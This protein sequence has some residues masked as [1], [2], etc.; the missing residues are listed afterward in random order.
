MKGQRWLKWAGILLFLVPVLLVLLFPFAVMIST[1]FKTLQ[2][3]TRIPPTFIPT[4]P[5]LQ[6]YVE[7]WR[8]VPLA[9][10]FLNS[11]L[12]GVGEAALVLAVG[13]PAAYALCRYR[14]AGRR[15]YLGF[16]LLTQMFPPVVVIL[17]LF[18]VVAALGLVDSRIVV[19]AIAAA[20]NLAFCIW[21]LSGYFAAVPVEIEEAAMID[22]TSRAGAMWRMTVRM[23]LPG[24]T[25]VA[26]FAFMDGWNEFLLSLTLIRT[27]QSLPLTVGLFRFVGRFQIHW[28]HLMTGS[29]LATL[30]A[31]ALFMLV[32]KNLT[33]GLT[34]LADG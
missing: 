25:T 12:L 29:L 6:N 34:G 22:G 1:S 24:L 4:E 5:T 27:E 9:R 28:P 7:V 11:L 21:L 26:I 15:V 14:F 32:Q 10:H 3:A 20:F 17:G 18:R 23:S 33:R 30:V 13:I 8:I 31:V 19:I 16:L 2:E